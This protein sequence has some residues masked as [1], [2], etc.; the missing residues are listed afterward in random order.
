MSASTTR[1]PVTVLV[2][3]K[4][5]ALN[6]GKCLRSLAPASRVVVLDS[7]SEDDT[8]AI[9]EAHG[10]EVIQFV[11]TPGG[12]RKRQWAMDSLPIGTPWILLVDA[13]EEIPPPLWDEISRA[14]ESELTDRVAG[15]F[16]RKGFHFLGRRFQ[17]GGFSFDSVLLFRT[18]QARFERLTDDAADGLDMEVHERL[19]VD[20][21][22]ARLCTPLVHN[23]FKSL[24][25]YIAKHNHYST[26]ES[27]LRYRFFTEGKWGQEAIRPRLFGNSQ[28]RRR[29]LK[30]LAI[31]LPFEPA[32]WFMYHYV[33][34]LG[35]LEGRRGLIAARIRSDYIAAVRAKVFELQLRR[36]CHT[37]APNTARTLVHPR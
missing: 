2:A 35:L 11:Y 16:I 34:R 28:E 17:H 20:G 14:L 1:I 25:H 3:A 33:F 12:P 7:G 27:R 30:K 24:E 9:A 22:I 13:D 10:A 29:F 18:G 6:I 19:I 8:A 23:D 37:P 15:F 31:R 26:W 21:A 5:E 4:N 32:L 36:E